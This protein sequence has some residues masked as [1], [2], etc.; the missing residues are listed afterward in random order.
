MF[1]GERLREITWQG[2]VAA[3]CKAVCSVNLRNGLWIPKLTVSSEPMCMPNF[4]SGDWLQS[5]LK[6]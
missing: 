4:H 2:K 1:G 6:F 5:I 3:Y